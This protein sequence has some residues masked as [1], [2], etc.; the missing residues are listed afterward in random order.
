MAA[1]GRTNREI[2]Q[3]LFVTVK[4]VEYHLHGANRKLDISSREQ[5]CG[6]LAEGA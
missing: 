1:A 6:A 3:E 4:T 5:L 2:A